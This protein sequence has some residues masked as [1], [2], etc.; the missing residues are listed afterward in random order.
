[1]TP[2]D[3]RARLNAILVRRLG[4]ADARRIG[5]AIRLL[6]EVNDL[7]DQIDDTLR[8]LEDSAPPQETTK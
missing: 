5:D 7:V 6:A 2:A 1:M 8:V 4:A 3:L